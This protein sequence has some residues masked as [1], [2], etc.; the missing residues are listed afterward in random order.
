[1]KIVKILNVVIILV[2]GISCSTKPDNRY[3]IVITGGEFFPE[4][5]RVIV[6][7]SKTVESPEPVEYLKKVALKDD[8]LELE[9][10]VN[11]IHIVSIDVMPKDDDHPYVRVTLPL[12]PGTTEIN[13]ISDH[14]YTIKGGGYTNKLVSVWNNNNEYK[15]AVEKIRNYKFT[16]YKD[17]LQ[18]A[19]Y[20]K[21]AKDMNDVKQ[22]LI[23]QE[24]E[25]SNDPLLKLL[26]YGI[27]YYGE[28]LEKRD[29]VV[30]ELVKR[31]GLNH[32]QSRVAILNVKTK[33][34]NMAAK[35]TIG[36]GAVI[37]DFEAK[38][39]KGETFHLVDVLKNNKYVLVEFW[40][41]WCGPCRAE[42]PHMKKAYSYFKDKGF[43]IV[44]FTLDHDRDRWEEASKE[45]QL[46]W[47]NTGDLLA[48]TSPVVKMYG[49]SG[50]PA[51]YLVE[52]ST[53]KIIAQNL[54]QEKLDEKLFELL[55]E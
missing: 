44:S 1:M 14:D 37:K 8:K 54:R 13:F 16:N 27:G 11:D 19:T 21:L 40:A 35:S 43:E 12:E 34:E 38:N 48:H 42:I 4:E 2:I 53:G 15:G 39:L 22:K 30:E 18:K 25:N 3:S 7:R 50:V 51:N 45:E 28:D 26:A 5:S 41:S 24:V 47:I 49:V 17:S 32:R 55:G 29:D 31:V 20:F 6:Y 46:P 9:G 23:G 10:E 33:R 36:I 52:A